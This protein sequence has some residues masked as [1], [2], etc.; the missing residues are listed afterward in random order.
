M[1]CHRCC[2]P[3]P[4]GRPIAEIEFGATRLVVCEECL[5]A[6]AERGEIPLG[7]PITVHPPE[8]GASAPAPRLRCQRDGRPIDDPA[9]AV[10]VHPSRPSPGARPVILCRPCL[11]QLVLR[12]LVAWERH[13]WTFQRDPRCG[14]RREPLPA[15]LEWPGDSAFWTRDRVWELA[16][17]DADASLDGQ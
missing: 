15:S 10:R 9:Q 7:T 1:I 12:G 2:L 14:E 3:A 8:R 6:M 13:G 5:H 11:T 16:R 17:L 4:P